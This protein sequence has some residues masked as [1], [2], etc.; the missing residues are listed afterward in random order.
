M[1]VIG[2]GARHVE[3]RELVER[4]DADRVRFLEYQPR[5]LLS[6]SLSA[7]HVHYVGLALGSLGL[8]RAEPPLRRSSPPAGR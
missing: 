4:L 3:M 7:A 5:E 6:E 2:S 8:R 1:P